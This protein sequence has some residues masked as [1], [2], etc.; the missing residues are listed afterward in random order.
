VVG[1]VQFKNFSQQVSPKIKEITVEF[2]ESLNGHNTGV[3][4]GDDGQDAFPKGTLNGR[5]WAED[6]KSWTIPVALEP[7]KKY[8]LLISN[9]FRTEDGIPLK[10]YLLEFNTASK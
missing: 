5:R 2:S 1:I 9:N 4:F 8:Q 10:P 6:N 7:N 3:D